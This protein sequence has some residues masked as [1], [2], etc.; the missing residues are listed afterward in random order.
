[1]TASDEATAVIGHLDALQASLSVAWAGAR[2]AGNFYKA[3]QLSP[4]AD[5]AAEQ[6]EA[7]RQSLLAAID[8]SQDVTD[9]L[10]RMVCLN[11]QL[12]DQQAA[13]AAGTA[14]MVQVGLA[15]DGVDKLLAAVKAA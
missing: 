7:A 4:L 14:D 3:A 15:L 2:K 6:L 12:H 1:M 5:R 10:A 13:V 11:Q 9:L 8:S